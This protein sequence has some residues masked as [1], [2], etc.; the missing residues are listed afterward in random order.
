[1]AAKFGAFVH[2]VDLSVNMV[3][4]ALERTVSSVNGQKVQINPQVP[5]LNTGHIFVLPLC[6]LSTPSDFFNAHKAKPHACNTVA[7]LDVAHLQ[8]QGCYS[9]PSN[10]IVIVQM[11]SEL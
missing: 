4:T 3:T 1:M 10:C 2:G 5:D 7:L 11:P 6:A 8:M 9:L